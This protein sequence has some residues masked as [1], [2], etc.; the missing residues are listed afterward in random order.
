[1]TAP[2]PL[3]PSQQDPANRPESEPV[4]ETLSDPVP[5]SPGPIGVAETLPTPETGAPVPPSGPLAIPGYEILGELGFGGMGVVYKARQVKLNRLVALKVIRSGSHAVQ[6]ERDRFR[7]EAEAVARLQHPGVVQVYEVGEHNGMPFYALEFCEG[8]SLDHHLGGTSQSPEQAAALVEV[9]ARAVEAAH[10]RGIIHRDLKPANI[11]LSVVGSSLS[12]AKGLEKS[13]DNGQRTMDNGFIPKITDFGLAKLLDDGTGH[14]QSGAVL[15]TPAYMAPEQARGKSKNVGPAADIYSL[16]AIL[17][18][19]LTGR[20]P[21]RGETSLD[22]LSQVL[23]DEPVSPRRHQRCPR[24]LEAICLKCLEKDPPRRYSSA[25]D[26]ADD[27]RR[28]LS[29]EPVQ[30]R[31]GGLLRSA[32]RVFRRYRWAALVLGVALTAVAGTALFLGSRREPVPE[33][34]PYAELRR[35]EVEREVASRRRTAP[36]R[37]RSHP[38]HVVAMEQVPLPDNSAFEILDDDRVWDLRDWHPVLPD[39]KTEFISAATLS[40]RLRLKKLREAKEYVYQSRTSGA[41]VFPRCLSHP[42]S[43]RVLIQKTP[44]HVG[45]EQTKTRQCVIDVSQIPLDKEFDLRFASTFWNSLQTDE[46]RWVGIMGYKNSFK[47]SLLLLF[48]EDRPFTE[49]WLT[50]ASTVKASAVPFEGRKILL[51]DSRHTY[52]YWEIL[53]PKESQ[54]YRVHWKW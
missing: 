54:V 21:F 23:N 41:E 30:A 24:D 47:V 19:C 35:Q 16:G 2:D 31:R 32:S 4:V 27:L 44:S 50:V 51:T 42:D 1:M 7:I 17:Y 52:L 12:V 34:D 14:T 8:G 53:E 9:L 15:G 43:F 45:F 36:L 5:S 49:Y 25:V 20:P 26:L 33:T 37:T 48:P 3:P 28:F 40:T 29:G 46:D 39:R 38:P 22:T 6:A 18:E 13:R 11:L 10:A